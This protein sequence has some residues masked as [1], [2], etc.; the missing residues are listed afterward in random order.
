MIK[1][2][3]EKEVD[4]FVSKQENVHETHKTFREWKKHILLISQF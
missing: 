1:Y 4:E 3:S 2:I